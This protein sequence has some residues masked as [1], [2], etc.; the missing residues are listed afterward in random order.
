MGVPV[1]KVCSGSFH[2]LAGL[3]EIKMHLNH[4]HLLDFQPLPDRAILD[5]PILLQG[6]LPRVPNAG[7][8]D[9]MVLA[10]INILIFHSTSQ[11][12]PESPQT[13]TPRTTIHRKTKTGLAGP[14]SIPSPTSFIHIF[15]SILCV[16]RLRC[17]TG[18]RLPKG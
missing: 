18:A 16:Q 1:P 10:T 2:S 9:T 4:R 12:L 8:P 5:P 6:E 14:V 13:P 7:N 17:R 15:S 3:S 11:I